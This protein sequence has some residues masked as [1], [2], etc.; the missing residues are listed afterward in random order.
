MDWKKYDLISNEFK[1]AREI[2]LAAA[3]LGAMARRGFVEIKEGSPK[4][5]R[6]IDSPAIKIYRLCEENKNDFETYFTLQKENT[7]YGMLCSIDSSG[8][9]V[10]CWGKKYDLTGVNYVKFRTKEF[11]I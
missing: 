8:D 5:Y 2:G 6:K 4:Q 7:P 11:Y 3:T 9:I 10:D 1:T